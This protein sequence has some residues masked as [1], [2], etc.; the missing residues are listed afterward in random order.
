MPSEVTI[1]EH[2]GEASQIEIPGGAF[3][4]VQLQAFVDAAIRRHPMANWCLRSSVWPFRSV[5][6]VKLTM[7]SEGDAT[8][9]LDQP[10]R[11]VVRDQEPSQVADAI[12]QR[13]NLL[14]PG[15]PACGCGIYDRALLA[16]FPGA[17]AVGARQS[18]VTRR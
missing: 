14:A 6:D 15:G 13:F 12:A 4:P 10:G 16:D 3:D 17:V 11:G 1:E 5:D 7:R 2:P 9:P 8:S 18:E